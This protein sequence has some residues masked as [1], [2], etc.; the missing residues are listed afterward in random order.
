MGLLQDI[1][2]ASVPVEG[3]H[4]DILISRKAVKL[5]NNHR[6]VR[7][8]ASSVLDTLSALA[9]YHDK[10]RAA[11]KY[12]NMTEPEHLSDIWGSQEASYPHIQ[13]L[14]DQ[15]MAS[16]WNTLSTPPS[17]E[18][19][20]LYYATPDGQYHGGLLVGGFQGGK[21]SYFGWGE[22]RN[23]YQFRQERDAPV[24]PEELA[25][26]VENGY[27][28]WPNYHAGHKW[29]MQNMGKEFL[30]N[31][32]EENL[33]SLRY[34]QGMGYAAIN[35]ALRTRTHTQPGNKSTAKLIQDIDEEMSQ[36]SVPDN[37]TLYRNTTTLQS[38]GTNDRSQLKGMVGS[39]FVDHAYLSTSF[40]NTISWHINPHR[41]DVAGLFVLRVPK[42][43]RG[44]YLGATA[45]QLYE[46]RESEVLLDRDY[47]WAIHG[48]EEKPH[49]DAPSKTYVEIQ[50]DLIGQSPRLSKYQQ[51]TQG[52]P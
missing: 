8:S 13:A 38:L 43:T 42:G 37:I 45:Q 16:W 23:D 49:P 7:L 40:N 34:Y 47:E 20:P 30:D 10:S 35:Q 9:E 29:A 15:G 11:G 22:L 52:K 5:K 33:L 19:K 46:E 32:S 50:M 26:V 24:A 41:V 1:F 3:G 31:L 28:H 14:V 18:D 27:R 17:D 12:L 39:K 44:V 4:A 48:V 6:R 2:H 25:G 51:L 21:N 36:N